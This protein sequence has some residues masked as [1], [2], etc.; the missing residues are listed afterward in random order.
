MG[1]AKHMYFVSSGELLYSSALLPLFGG[2]VTRTGTSSSN[3]DST[4]SDDELRLSLNKEM[5]ACR[6]P[7]ARFSN[8]EILNE[9]ALWMSFSHQGDLSCTNHGHCLLLD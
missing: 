6:C 4:G 2:S 5:A 8:S 1:P 9:A 3:R 7:I